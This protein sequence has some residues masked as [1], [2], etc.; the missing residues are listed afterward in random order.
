MMLFTFVLS[1]NELPKT[2]YKPIAIDERLFVRIG[3]GDNTALDELYHLTE[4]TL[5]AFTVSL[6]RDHDMALEIM[7]ETYLKIL[8][9]AHLYKPMGKPLAWMFTITKNLYY[10]EVKKRGR[11]DVQDP[12]EISNERRFSYVTDAEDRMVLEGVLKKLTEEEREIIMLYA[13]SGMKHRE[14]AEN[15]DMKLSTLLS[16]YHRGL[17]KLKDYLE[18]KEG[19]S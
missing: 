16:K 11:Y 10:S 13:V 19:R 1:V 7:Q 5:Y 14:I 12:M 2:E 18:E 3:K 4:R 6:T 8:S 17:K 15:L 9:A